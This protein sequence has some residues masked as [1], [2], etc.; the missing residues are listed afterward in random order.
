MR[1]RS[2]REAENINS[3]ALQNMPVSTDEPDL[4]EE[5]TR[6]ALAEALVWLGGLKGGLARKLSA[7]THEIDR[8]SRPARRRLGM[9]KTGENE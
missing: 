3:A 6:K 1:N 8:P 5:D 2:Q 4:T 9:Q 7:S